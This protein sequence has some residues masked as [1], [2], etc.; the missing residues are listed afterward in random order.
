MALR[1][2]LS[3]SVKY[4]PSAVSREPVAVPRST[5]AAR[6]LTA[7]LGVLMIVQ[8]VL[9]RACSE[10]YRDVAWIRASWLGNDWVTLLV[11]VPLLVVGAASANRRRARGI[12]LWLGVTAYAAYNYAF[13]LFGAALNVFFPL[14]VALV[15]I[16]SA[17]LIHT[18][19]ATAVDDVGGQFQPFIPAKVVGGYFVLVG[20][21]LTV[22]W[23]TTWAA[24][25]FL[26]RLIPVDA[27][28]FRV[29]AGLDLIILVPPLVLGGALLWR[30]SAWGVLVA[31]IAGVQ[32]SLYLLVLSVNAGIAVSGRLVSPPGEIPIWIILMMLT[33]AATAA[34]FVSICNEAKTLQQAP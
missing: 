7:V 8:A 10:Q 21:A 17:I 23:I 22:V 34:L 18:L 31:T 3:L 12:A 16:A 24:M 26:G 29:I 19:W 27:D 2:P 9:G 5:P 11:A 6:H 1:N 4:N 25:V 15:L 32:S 13:Y 14:Y 28:T 20:V 30:K 33:T